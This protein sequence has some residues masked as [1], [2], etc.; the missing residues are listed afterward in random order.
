MKQL[1]FLLAIMLSDVTN[2]QTSKAY[3]APGD[4]RTFLDYNLGADKSLPATTPSLGI[5]GVRYQWGKSDPVSFASWGSPYATDNSWTDLAKSISDP[6]PSGYRVPTAA[7][8]QGVIENNSIQW[9]GDFVEESTNQ[10]TRHSSG[11]LINNSLFLPAA[12]INNHVNGGIFSNNASG[13]YWSSNSTGYSNYAKA[14]TFYKSLLSNN[15]IL[16]VGYSADKNTGA[17]V[18]C[19]KDPALPSSFI[20][21]TEENE[22]AKSYLL[23]PNPAKT[24]FS[25]KLKGESKVEVYD[26]TGRLLVKRILK[27]E[28][29]KVNIDNLKDG[30]YFVKIMNGKTIHTE[31]LFKSNN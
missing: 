7:E 30:L 15:Q 19:I 2:A 20:L 22:A 6:C 21:S 17:N 14:L 9:V 28:S 1:F 16:H 25:L 31:L 3:V 12:G 23:Y 26:N 13:T 24:S 29:D 8:W 10:Y 18:R 27:S 5:K 4:L 11:L